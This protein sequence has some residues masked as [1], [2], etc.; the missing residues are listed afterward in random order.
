MKGC[1]NIK[2][3]KD[4]TICSCNH[5]TNFAA[6]YFPYDA[7]PPESIELS[8]MTYICAV[9]SIVSCI[10]TIGAHLAQHKHRT[11]QQKRILINICFALI[12]RDTFFLI[13]T[14]ITKKLAVIIQ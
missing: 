7:D 14:F 6:L 9:I 10:I 5:L 1:L 12:G 4:Y 13:G 11:N 3:E 2:Q 8:Y